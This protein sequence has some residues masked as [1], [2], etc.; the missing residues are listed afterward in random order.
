M[1]IIINVHYYYIILSSTWKNQT[2][3]FNY[4]NLL[5]SAY[6]Q[7]M[8]YLCPKHIVSIYLNIISKCVHIIVIVRLLSC[9]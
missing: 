4:G 1:S 5:V 9:F 3:K 6:K 8:A 2:I 7:L